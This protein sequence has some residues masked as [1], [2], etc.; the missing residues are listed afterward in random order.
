LELLN[1][2]GVNAHKKTAVDAMV[3]KL[4]FFVIEDNLVAGMK[5]IT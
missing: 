1:L 4:I 2:F 5:E 3:V